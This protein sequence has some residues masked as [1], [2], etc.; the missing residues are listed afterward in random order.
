MTEKIDRI[1][2]SIN[3]SDVVGNERTIEEE[4]IIRMQLHNHLQ[5]P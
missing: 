2:V 5:A 3:T 1:T 4:N